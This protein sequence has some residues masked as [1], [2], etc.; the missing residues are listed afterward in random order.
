MQSSY[1]FLCNAFPATQGDS[2]SLRLCYLCLVTVIKIPDKTLREEGLT[3][4][5]KLSED[6]PHHVRIVWW[7]ERRWS[8]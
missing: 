3:L 4:A 6:R 2:A 1:C 7:Q 8:H 5:Y